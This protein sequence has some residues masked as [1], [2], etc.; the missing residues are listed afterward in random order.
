MKPV[1]ITISEKNPGEFRG[2]L[3]VTFVTRT[4]EGNLVC[5]TL[6]KP[7]L[8][9]LADVKEFTGKKEQCLQ[10]YP[11]IDKEGAALLCKRVLFVGLGEIDKEAEPHAA[12]ELFRVAGGVIAGQCKKNKAVKIAVTVP[13]V[14]DIDQVDFGEYLTEGILLGCYQFLKYKTEEKEPYPGLKK[15]TFFCRNRDTSLRDALARGKNS[16]TA[17]CVAR[18]MAN[19]PGNGWTPA[20]F[21]E[22]ARNCAQKFNLQCKVLEKSHMKKL[23][24]EGILGVNRGSKEAPKLVILEYSPGKKVDTILLVGKGL[25]FDSGGVSLKPAQGMMDMKYDMCGGAAVL[26]AMQTIAAEKPDVRVVAVV[27]STDN[28]SG[29]G[30]LK[31]GDI[32]KHYGGITSEIENTDAEGRLI[33]ADA[34]AYGIEKFKPDCVIDL[35]TLTGAVIFALGHHYSGLMSNNDMLAKRLIEA[36]RFSGEPLW[37]LPLGE[38]YRE[39]I[40]SNVADIKNTGGKPA[41]SITAAEYLHRFV[42]KVPWAHLDIAGTAW[43]FTEKSYIPKGPSGFGVRT[44]IEL[45]RRWEN[46]LLGEENLDE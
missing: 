4:T 17:A 46:G 9:S 33:L 41:G 45:V 37:R 29:G 25:T 31:P 10:L 43:D 36:S 5:D 32:I 1:K 2:E 26:A 20:H 15:L 22:Y 39:Q 38:M 18:D 11:G 27:P 6:F 8:E 42:G 35:A 44:L 23:R 7:L 19:E 40:K 30:A 12:N 14:A 3:L 24:M 28:M 13:E 16:A 34:L 21:A